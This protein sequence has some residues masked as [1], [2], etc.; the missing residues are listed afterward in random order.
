LTAGT[1]QDDASPG[2]AK[3]QLITVRADTEG[4]GYYTLKFRYQETKPIPFGASASDVEK[5]LQSLQLL[6]SKVHVSSAGSNQFLVEFEPL[7]TT[8]ALDAKVVPLVVDG[9][10]NDDDFRVA[11]IYEEMY[12]KGGS[13]LGTSSGG[14]HGDKIWLNVYADEAGSTPTQFLLTDVQPH[15]TIN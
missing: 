4:N 6:G 10:N 15:L 12:F 1:L 8:V 9:G 13:E 11:S 14:T 2:M 5:A 3:Q 7:A